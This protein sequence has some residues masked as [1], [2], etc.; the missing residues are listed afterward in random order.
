MNSHLRIPLLAL[1]LVGALAAPAQAATYQSGKLRFTVSGSWV[2]TGQN[3]VDCRNA[4][5][6]LE[7]V[8]FA[9]TE[10]VRVT[11]LSSGRIGYQ[12]LVGRS[13][14][15]NRIYATPKVT[16]TVTRTAPRPA[17]DDSREAWDCG[18]KTLRGVA[19]PEFEGPFPFGT[20]VRLRF[21]FARTRSSFRFDDPFKTCPGPDNGPGWFAAAMTKAT[22]PFD[23][24]AA[25]LD[26]P[27]P[28]GFYRKRRQTF[29]GSVTKRYKGDAGRGQGDAS[30][31]LKM[32]VGIRRGVSLSKRR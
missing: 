18:S 25:A 26:V 8:K 13:I 32:K 15:F 24:Q 27:S 31:T 3:F 19:N 4:E 14:F 11:G 21:D 20:A 6:D 28:K 10:R 23:W 29:S 1:L 7:P 16:V 2:H 30:A 17:C 22:N 9:V 5:G 12:G